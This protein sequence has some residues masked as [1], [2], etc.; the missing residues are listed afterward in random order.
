MDCMKSQIYFCIFYVLSETPYFDLKLD[1]VI[2]KHVKFLP[3]R[4]Q[5]QTLLDLV[6]A[7]LKTSESLVNFV[8]CDGKVKLGRLLILKE[9]PS[10]YFLFSFFFRL[11]SFFLLFFLS[12]GHYSSYYSSSMQTC[13]LLNDFNHIQLRSSNGLS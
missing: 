2:E 4:Q 8:D 6:L 5:V 9:I 13:V 1:G 11:Y 7:A 12:K 10:C 3:S